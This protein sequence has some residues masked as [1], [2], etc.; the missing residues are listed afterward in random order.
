MV[1]PDFV[2]GSLRLLRVVVSVVLFSDEESGSAL[3]A[4]V[5]DRDREEELRERGERVFR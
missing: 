3:R 2:F 1:R 5:R 4:R